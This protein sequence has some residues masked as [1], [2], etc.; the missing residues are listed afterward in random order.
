MDPLRRNRFGVSVVFVAHGAV[1]G[2]FATRVPWLADHVG[3]GTGRLGLALLFPAIGAMATMSFSGRL[4]HRYEGRRVT[5]L[6]LAAWCLA[7]PLPAL[8][9][10]L[11][12]LCAALLVYGSVS[13]MAD[14]AMNAQAVAVENRYGR[15]IMSGLHGLWSAGGLAAS[16]I[17]VAA[18]AVGLDA[19]VHFGLMAAVLLVVGQLGGR[20][21]PTVRPDPDAAE[22]P[23]FALPPRPVLLIGLVGFCAVFGEAAGSD[24][25]AKYLTDVAGAGQGIAAGAY[26]GFAC[27][28]AAARL[29]GDRVV[30][31]LGVV[32]T[33]RLGGVLSA[34]GA[35]LIVL[36]RA[37]VPGIVGFALLGVGVS[38]VVPLTFT[39]AGAATSHPG[40]AIAGVATISY[41]AGLAA[42]AVI[43]GIAAGT[44]LPVSFLVVAAL[45]VL[46]AVGAGTFRTRRP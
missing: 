22:P 3:V 42:P 44:S 30:A 28:M 45:A 10:N 19:R 11:P 39:A 34:A 31:R 27:A 25:A 17:G 32:G 8:A 23:A 14:V 26:T 15:P 29:V 38:V 12:L 21:L 43:G 40:H 5:R 16:G 35:V 13:G 18:A 37:P 20:L 24:W 33:V 1:T 6:L 41:G 46:I 9:P 36:S 2:S 7:L 4:L